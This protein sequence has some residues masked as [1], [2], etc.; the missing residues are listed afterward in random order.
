MMKLLSSLCSK[1]TLFGILIGISMSAVFAF[2]VLTDP[3][4]CAISLDKMN[5][6]YLGVDNPITIVAR[7]VP[8]GQLVVEAVGVTLVKGPG[9]QYIVRGTTPGEAR[10]TVSGGDLMKTTFN[11]RVRRIP[12]PVP[13]L[14]NARKESCF[15]PV[16]FKTN[17]GI[18]AILEYFDFDAKCEVIGYKMTYIPKDKD[19]IAVFNS[20]AKFGESA[21]ALVNQAKLGD[22][23]FFDEIKVKCPGDIVARDIGS[24]SY[25]IK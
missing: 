9:D 12:D 2:K 20:G 11:Y 14:I 21:Q 25:P 17:Q 15:M 8:T 13:R 3:P 6:F 5:V 16:S 18:T 22:Q 10:I 7:G 23:Y 1:N 4:A 19:P 24:L